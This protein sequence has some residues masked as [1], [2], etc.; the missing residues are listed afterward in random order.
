MKADNTVII[1][2]IDHL[3]RLPGLRELQI[4]NT[5]H[6]ERLPGRKIADLKVIFERIHHPSRSKPNQQLKVYMASVCMNGHLGKRIVQ[7]Q[8]SPEFDM[9]LGQNP[10]KFHSQNSEDLI[11][12][13]PVKEV[14]LDLDFIRFFFDKELPEERPISYFGASGF[15]AQKYPLINSL[16]VCSRLLVPFVL[17]K[18]IGAEPDL[19]RVR[20]LDQEV[21]GE[22]GRAKPIFD[23]SELPPAPADSPLESGSQEHLEDL[24]LIT[25]YLRSYFLK[26]LH[27]EPEPVFSPDGY[28]QEDINLSYFHNIYPG[29][30]NLGESWV[31]LLL[32]S[33][34]HLAY[35][36]I[37]KNEFSQNFFERLVKIPAL[38]KSLKKL[39][40]TSAITLNLVS[41][42]EFLEDLPNLSIF[43]S[44]LLYGEPALRF[45]RHLNCP[46]LFCLYEFSR[47]V[48]QL[49]YFNSFII[50]KFKNQLGLI[51]YDYSWRNPELRVFLRGG[52]ID[53]LL[54]HAKMNAHW[55]APE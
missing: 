49:Y 18:L 20:R 50:R 40:I 38:S 31:L 19:Q 35:L 6:F 8:G 52:T 2:L 46:G 34:P 33:F 13:I 29:L 41:S 32:S 48:C 26:F 28:Y 44:N 25:K 51:K 14:L 27:S 24:E 47:E 22:I 55:P 15:F 11:E 10:L 9:L 3:L 45:V 4:S 30:Y 54:E 23:Q 36:N 5:L 7:T 42:W 1:P 21:R 17:L 43:E 53:E 39:T 16:V 37:A 12:C